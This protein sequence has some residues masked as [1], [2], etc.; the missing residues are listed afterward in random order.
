MFHKWQNSVTKPQ[1][2]LQLME[3]SHYALKRW[4]NIHEESYINSK[5]VSVNKSTRPCKDWSWIKIYG[6]AFR[7]LISFHTTD[8]LKKALILILFPSRSF[9]LLYSGSNLSSY[10]MHLLQLVS[11]RQTPKALLLVKQPTTVGHKT[12]FAHRI[13]GRCL[14]PLISSSSR[15]SRWL[16]L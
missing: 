6:V 5:F 2:P 11:N 7:Q 9:C 10:C 1:N 14:P 3:Q 12:I 4:T 8:Q 15:P 13:S 16:V